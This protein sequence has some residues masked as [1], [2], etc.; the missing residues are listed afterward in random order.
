MDSYARYHNYTIEDGIKCK[1][2]NTK[3]FRDCDLLYIFNCLVEVG[4]KVSA[5]TGN[6]YLGM[7]QSHRLFFSTEGFLKVYPFKLLPHPINDEHHSHQTEKED[8]YHTH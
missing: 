5:L 1:R 7:F 8:C 2:K 4:N 3:M 6:T